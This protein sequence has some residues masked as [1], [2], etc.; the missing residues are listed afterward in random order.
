V[1]ASLAGAVVWTG[2]RQG[3]FNRE[4]IASLESQLLEQHE[5]EYPL[6]P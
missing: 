4:Q 5:E 2:Q 1:L 3:R 6:P